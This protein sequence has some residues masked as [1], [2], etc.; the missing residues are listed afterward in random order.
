MR[1]LG[2][3]DGRHRNAVSFV[4]SPLM[5]IGRR[6]QVA[7]WKGWDLD[8]PMSATML[9]RSAKVVHYRIVDFDKGERASVIDSKMQ[10]SNVSALG[11]SLIS[12]NSVSHSPI[13]RD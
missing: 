8:M 1:H 6:V 3:R 2:M 10:C 5:L 13:I 9:P 11:H 4:V 7:E 12:S